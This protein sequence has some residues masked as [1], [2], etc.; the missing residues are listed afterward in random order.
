MAYNIQL[1]KADIADELVKIEMVVK[2]FNDV[3]KKIEL[4]PEKVPNYDRGAVGYLLHN[5]YNGC[6]NIFRSIARFFEN[7]LGQST[8]HKDLL[9][10]MKMEI[11]GYRPRVIDDELYARLDDF[12]AFR[13]KFRHAYAFE[14]D[15]EREQI[16]ARKLLPTSK[17]LKKQ[18]NHF[19]D[20][21]TEIDF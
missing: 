13:H 15:W 5:F 8:W 11:S 6:E 19:L 12:R 21:I 9:K 14:L 18:I 4:P 3:K 20:Q 7:D 10:R 1:L 16:V 17:M 2:E